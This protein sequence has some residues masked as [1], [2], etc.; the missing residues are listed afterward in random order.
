MVDDTKPKSNIALIGGAI[1]VIVIVALAALLLYHPQQTATPVTTA[2]STTIPTSPVTSTNATN[3]VA[4]SNIWVADF[5]NNTVTELSS[6]GTLLGT[7]NVGIGPAGIAIAP[8]GNIWVADWIS[9]TT[10]ELSSTGTL[11]GT[12]RG[13]Q[14]RSVAIAPN[15]NVWVTNSDRRCWNC[16]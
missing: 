2:Y 7:F 14:P 15:G 11:L 10:T 3:T 16:S 8:N 5:G 9:N 12:F 6:T 1:A 13:D 4:S